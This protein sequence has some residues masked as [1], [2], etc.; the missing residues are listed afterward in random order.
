MLTRLPLFRY[1]AA[2]LLALATLVSVAGAQTDGTIGAD[3]GD[4]V[5]TARAARIGDRLTIVGVEM[6]LRGMVD[7]NLTRFSV[8]A[9]DALILAADEIQPIP[10]NVYLRGSLAG[11]FD[12]RVVLSIKE[13]GTVDGLI[14]VAGEVWQLSSRLR[15]AGL[16]ARRLDTL[17]ENRDRPFECQTNQLGAGEP[18]S[19]LDETSAVT[20][21]LRQL[22]S[23]SYTARVAVDTDWEFLDKFGGDVGAATDY[24]GDLFA[25]SSTIYEEEV[26][27]SL[28]IGYLKWWP[29]ANNSSDPWTQ[30]GCLS[31]LFEFR[32]YWNQNQ[33]GVQRT[34][35]HLLSGK[36]TGCGIAYVGVLCS[37]S[38]GYGLTGS[39]SGNFDPADP[40]SGSGFWDIMAMSHEIGHNFGSSHTHCYQGVPNAGYPDAVDHCYDSTNPEDPPPPTCYQGTPSL[41]AGCSPGDRCGTIMSY[42]HLRSGGY[43]NISL[44]FG[45]GHPHGVDAWRVPSVMNSHVVSRAQSYPTCLPAIGAEEVFG[46]DF[47]SGNT[48]SW[49]QVVQ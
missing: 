41:P 2:S 34:V 15:L 3:S 49:N 19:W 43:G 24:V 32:D 26:D 1:L 31:A 38:S 46:D 20:E 25:F 7:L 45:Q 9:E 14:V 28:Y 17:E 22:E 39:L 47:E 16:A 44:T 40:L 33:G 11:T 29:G 36:N 21:P 42:C 8:F 5:E 10:A 23:Y 13:D 48:S 6:G 30:S 18:I 37:S 4:L 35:A 27:T 12:S